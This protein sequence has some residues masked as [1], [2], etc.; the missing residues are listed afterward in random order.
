MRLFFGGICAALV[1]CAGCE[2]RIEGEVDRAGRTE[3]R[4]NA[5]LGPRISALI[6]GLSARNAAAATG[7]LLSAPEIERAFRAIG[8]VEA[9]SWTQ[10]TP[11]AVEGR[12]VIRKID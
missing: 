2:T 9:S 8:G 1:L 6:R 11:S 10:K 4:V 5:A 7:A 3:L 12:L